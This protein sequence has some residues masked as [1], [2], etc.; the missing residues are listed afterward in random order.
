MT[1][2]AAVFALD[3][4][5]EPPAERLPAG[6]PFPPLP[7]PPDLSGAAGVASEASRRAFMLAN[8]FG[9]IQLHRAG[10][11]AWLGNP[12]TGYQLLLTTTG[13]K[14]G[15][16]R[17]VP[18]EYI[19]EDGSAWVMA[20]YGPRTQWY[21][22]LQTDPRVEVLLPGG[23]AFAATAEEVLDPAIRERLIVA[24]CRACGLPGFMIGANPWTAPA[25]VILKQV[26]WVPLVRITPLAGPLVA[27]PDDP[28]GLAWIP[29]QALALLATA[30]LA[31]ALLRLVRH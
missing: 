21:R 13:R 5:P 14:S 31:R 8:R 30:C 12:F 26:A 16:R 18:L 25:E 23:R 9:M 29:R 11:A 2:T 7:A 1:E 28:G 27:G 17:D 19:V 4:V 20:G 22:N 10:L 6:E 3:A 24:L 15:L